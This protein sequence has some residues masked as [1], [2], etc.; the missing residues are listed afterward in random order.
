MAVEISAL[1]RSQ[2]GEKAANPRRKMLLKDMLLLLGRRGKLAA[3]QPGHN[4]AQ[5][6]GVILRLM[7]LF[8]TLDA[9]G[10]QIG[11]QPR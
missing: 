4:L 3:D 9:E 5:N 1:G 7:L 11:T 2:V 8:D 6:R 10:P